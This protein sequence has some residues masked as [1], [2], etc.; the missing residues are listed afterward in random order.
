MSDKHILRLHWR[1][2]L[3]LFCLLW[4][5]IG[6]TMIY[7]VAHEKHRLKANL[8]NRL[9]NVNYTVIDAYERGGDMQKTV[10]FIRHFTDNTTL[11]P[12][13]ITVYDKYGKM[14][15]DN[16]GT[17]IPFQSDFGRALDRNDS[18]FV[19]DVMLNGEMSMLSAKISPD[20]M[21]YSFAA[22]PYEAGVVDFLSY[23]RM[24]WIVVVLLGVFSSVIAYAGTKSVCRNVYTLRDFANA[25]ST[26]NLPDD[27]D[28]MRFSKDEMGEVSRNLLMLYRDKIH[29]EQ[30]KIHHEQQIGMNVRHELKTPVGI[31][32][33]YLDTILADN[34]MPDDLKRKFLQRAQQNADRLT[35]LINDISMVMTL[36][37]AKN[38]VFSDINFHDLVAQIAEDVRQSHIAGDM[39]FSFAIPSG[40]TVKAQ[41]SLLTNALLNLIYNAAKHSEGT[42]MRLDWTGMSD[43]C[44]KFVFADNGNGVDDEHLGRL[45]DMF[46]RVDSGRARKNGGAGLGLPLVKRII[47]FFGGTISVEN[48][49]N[50]GLMF[51]F[52]LPV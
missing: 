3:P 20:G 19:T 47:T 14:L 33:G 34:E 46:Y 44:H 43:G 13:R 8:E 2:F 27:I 49:A 45:F 4:L 26:D 7:F 23:D 29:A 25:V 15:A 48:S 52:T 17:T 21:I 24:V 50:G 39:E 41:E 12:L 30:E 10:D 1:L 35:T 38:I 31:I 16:P 9:M 51:T 22:L 5:I 18:P 28:S 36:D 40:C 37:P 42:S 11:A 6:I 32:K